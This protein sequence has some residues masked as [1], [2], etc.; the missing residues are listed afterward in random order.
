MF[1]VLEGGWRP[2]MGWRM[3]CR[4]KW[5][6][7]HFGIVL[8]LCSSWTR[9]ERYQSPEARFL[10]L[11]SLLRQQR[12]PSLCLP[13]SFSPRCNQEYECPSHPP[14]ARGSATSLFICQPAPQFYFP[15]ARPISG[16]FP[17]QCPMLAT[18]CSRV[19][20]LLAQELG[21]R[22]LRLHH[23][24]RELLVCHSVVHQ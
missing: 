11:L 23:S 13:A 20:S 8:A 15:L 10:F 16:A 1:A 14:C 4:N 21:W 18:R 22:T 19:C 3:F 9:N 7:R 12:R 6:R 5:S 2:K 17:M 24:S